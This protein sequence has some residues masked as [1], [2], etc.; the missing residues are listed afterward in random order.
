[1][2]QLYAGTKY[3]LYQQAVDMRKGSYGLCGV[4][5]NEMKQNV[6]HRDVFVFLNK[7]RSTIKLL[8]W[9]GDGFSLYEK[10]LAKGTFERKTEGDEALI[11]LTHYQLQCILQGI[12]LESI[13]MKKRWHKI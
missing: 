4:V 3:Y 9:E 2:V 8:Q 1:M 6:M 12:I 11:L 5:N 10:K 7:K 13:R